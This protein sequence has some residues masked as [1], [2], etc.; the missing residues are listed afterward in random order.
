MYLVTLSLENEGKRINNQWQMIAINA[1][2]THR[3][4]GIDDKASCHVYKSEMIGD[5]TMENHCETH[6]IFYNGN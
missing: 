5:Y 3:R 4:G 6:N 1:V 2:I